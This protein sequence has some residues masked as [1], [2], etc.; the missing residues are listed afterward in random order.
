MRPPEKTF[1]I[2]YNR[3]SSFLSLATALCFFSSNSMADIYKF[4]T[5]DGV[6]TFTD[7]PV[8]REAR[9]FI[10]EHRSPVARK[11]K[12]VAKEKTHELSLDEIAEKTVTASLK[13]EYPSK[14]FEP[15]LPL[16]H[17]NITSGTGMRIDP[18]DGKWR[19]HNGIDIAVPEGTQVKPAAPG[20]VI[21]SGFRSG[22]GNTV[23]VEHEN[24]LITLYG[25]NSRLLVNNGEHVGA[26]NPIALSGNT[27]RSNGPHLHFEA[28]QSG[29]NVTQSFIPGNTI[30]LPKLQLASVKRRSHFRKEIL[31][32]GSLLFTN[33]PASLP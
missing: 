31:A 1:N 3:L 18:I 11:S 19:H 14:D 24:G 23:L 12:K 33:I 20:I 9:V 22:Y 27:G 17:G 6:E 2:R 7:S 16:S 13:A 8:N 21:Y 30:K 26:E 32:D 29:V 28:W 15:R 4:V 10:K 5:I 25:H